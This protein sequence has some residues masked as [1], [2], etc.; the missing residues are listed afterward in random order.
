VSNCPAL[1][2]FGDGKIILSNSY[3]HVF[4]VYI[5]SLNLVGSCAT[6]YCEEALHFFNFIKNIILHCFL[7]L[8]II[9]S[10]INI[11]KFF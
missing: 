11:D 9:G 5:F 8:L 3:T 10:G 2:H 7:H 4:F 1:P 6:I